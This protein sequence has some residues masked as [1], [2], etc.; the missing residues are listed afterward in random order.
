MINCPI[1]QQE[2]LDGPS[3]PRRSRSD[4]REEATA[5]SSVTNYFREARVIARGASPFAFAISRH[6]DESDEAILRALERLSFSSVRQLSYVT[7]P[8]KTVYRRFSEKLGFPT[9]HLQ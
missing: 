6:I 8:Q 9:L 4:T 1:S 7:H 3:Q 2:R 5:D